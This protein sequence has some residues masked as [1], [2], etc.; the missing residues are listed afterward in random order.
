[1]SDY[2]FI[3]TGYKYLTSPSTPGKGIQNPFVP[4]LTNLSEL[5][6]IY[7]S[8]KGKGEGLSETD[9]TTLQP[10]LQDGAQN[11]VI[12]AL[13]GNYDVSN[14]ML[15]NISNVYIIA[16]NKSKAVITRKI[17]NT[18]FELGNSNVSVHNLSIIGFKA[19]GTK[20]GSDNF[21]IFGPG[22]G[23]NYNAYYIYLSDMAWSDYS[24]VLY[25]GLHSH[26]WTI[27]K[28]VFYNST[29]EYIWYMMGWHHTLMNSVLYNNSYL[30]VVIRGSYP[31]DEEYIYRGK[32]KLIG[33]RTEHFLDNNDW[34]HMIINN[35]F[36]S[37]HHFVE[38][39]VNDVHMGLWYDLPN[40]EKG[41]TEDCYFPP[42]NIIIANNVF[43]DTGKENKKAI[44]FAASRGIND[45]NQ[46]NIASVNGVVISSNYTDHEQ[47][48][49]PFDKTDMSSI[50]LSSN[51][52]N[53]TNF[54]FDD[55]NRDYQLSPSSGLIDKGTVDIYFPDVDNAGN[56]RNQYPDVGAFE[57]VIPKEK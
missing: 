27:D 12:V 38:D 39:H 11:M 56:L 8:P 55:Q 2:D 30:G 17:G 18:N 45:P 47:L 33:N 22:N 28:S 21:F 4:D 16:K 42:K 24:C 37:C 23:L 49:V 51:V 36:G 57:L 20:K 14:L 44:L 54:G 52:I 40:Y 50:D 1:L 53:F 31:P 9:P 32:N 35:T 29:Y 43:I 5:D 15:Q 34:T 10:I 26:D 25:G 13:D 46:K 6:I 7:V 48:I 3:G 19:E 41:R